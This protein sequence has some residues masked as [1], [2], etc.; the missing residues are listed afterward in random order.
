MGNNFNENFY[1]ELAYTDLNGNDYQEEVVV[2]ANSTGKQFVKIGAN[3]SGN[4][5][6]DIY[7]T[8]VDETVMSRSR[9]Y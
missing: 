7:A 6:L 1:I 9:K 3:I 5:S 2:A 4:Q 8:I